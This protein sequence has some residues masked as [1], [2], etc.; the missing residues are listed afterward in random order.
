MGAG[1]EN[2]R[3]QGRLTRH[4]PPDAETA[5]GFFPPRQWRPGQLKRP[6]PLLVGL[7]FQR[8]MS[9]KGWRAGASTPSG[10]P[11]PSLSSPFFELD[12]GFKRLDGICWQDNAGQASCR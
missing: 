5:G 7:M 1:G 9:T 11:S 3:R 4:L 10:T 12:R 8:S 2:L 6:R